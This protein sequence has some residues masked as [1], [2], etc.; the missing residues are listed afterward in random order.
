MNEEEL[1]QAQLDEAEREEFDAQDAQVTASNER[2]KKLAETTAPSAPYESPTNEKGENTSGPSS[3]EEQAKGQIPDAVKNIGEGAALAPAAV[4]DFAMD[5]VGKVPGLGWLDDEYDKKTRFSNPHLQ[6]ARE[7][8]SI[9][10]PSVTATIFA[11]R[12]GAKVAGPAL[13]KGLSAL[14]LTAAADVGVTAISDVSERD[15]T[16]LTELDKLAPNLNIPDRFKT[17]DSDSPEVRREKNMYE[18]AGLSVIGDV[19]GYAL[20]AGKPLMKWFKPLN[21]QADEYLAAQ[22][23]TL[24]DQD[25]AEAVSKLDEAIATADPKTAKGL[26]SQRDALIKEAEEIGTSGASTNPLESTVSRNADSR[27]MQYDEDG[28]RAFQADPESTNYNPNITSGIA[29]E[30]SVARQSIPPANVARNMADTT[31]L[32]AGK[33]IGDPAPVITT[34]MMKKGLQ[35]DGATRDVVMEIAE[36]SRAVGK[37]NAVVDGFRFTKQEMGQA[38]WKIY[39][40]IINAGSA[41]DLRQMFVSG[42]DVKNILDGEITYINE[43]QATAVGF[44]M[45]DL[46]NRYVGREVT[47]SSARVM[48]T[49]GREIGSI[50]KAAKDFGDVTDDQQIKSLILGKLNF[51]MDEYAINKYI[52]GWTLQNKK[53]WKNLG[54]NAD[55]TLQMMKGD[56]DKAVDVRKKANAKLIDSLDAAMDQNPQIAMALPEAFSLSNGDVDTIAKMMK[57]AEKQLN[58][59][60]MIASGKEGMNSF[61]AGLWAVR[62]NNMLSGI[63]ALRAGLGTTTS[64]MLKPINHMIGLGMESLITGDFNHIRS[65]MYAYGAYLETN[66][67]ALKYAWDSFKKEVKDP[68]SMAALQR[69]DFNPAKRQGQL[70]EVLD[71]AATQWDK[72]KDYGKL[73]LYNWD[74]T[75]HALAKH[76]A[77]RYGTNAMVGIDAFASS[78]MA[79]HAARFEAYDQVFR[80]QALG[81]ESISNA[82]IANYKKHFGPNGEITSQALRSSTGEIALNLDSPLASVIGSATNK[83]PLLKSLFTFPK[84]GIEAFRLG[85]SYTPLTLIPGV[86]RTSDILMAGDDLGKIKS[87]LANHG[88][89]LDNTPG[90]MQMYKNLKAEYAGRLAFS[91]MVVTGLTGFALAG[92]IRGNG[93]PN[94]GRRKKMRDNNQWKAKTVKIGGKWVDYSAFGEPVDSVLTLVG[95]M[96]Y[97]M[98]D[99]NS[100]IMEDILTKL[101]WTFAATFTNKT[102]V[103]QLEPLVALATG[104]EEGWTRFFANEARSFIPLSGAAGVLAEAISDSRKDIYKDMNKYVQ[105]RL[106]GVNAMLPEETDIY[107]GEPVDY[108]D[109]PLLRALSALS[110]IKVNAGTEPWRQTL[111]DIG[112]D[113][114]ARISQ[115]STGAA[116]YPAE[117]REEIY[118]MVG[119]QKPWQKI[120]RELG[121]QKYQDDM[122]EIRKARIQGVSSDEI[123]ARDFPLFDRLDAIMNEEVKLAELRLMERSPNLR[124]YIQGSQRAQLLS[125]QG[126][127]DEAVKQV[128]ENRQTEKLIKMHK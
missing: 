103:S 45:R 75:N 99:I 97:Y 21:K 96:A 71:A 110:P 32:K 61:S 74:K 85:A 52:A 15:S 121:Y 11:G 35:V 95:D 17:L 93:D 8:L 58:P 19:L 100:T 50:S 20:M 24:L 87:A 65:G 105:N 90:A 60:G 41:Q 106:P 3:P 98:R 27:A 82:E 81:K 49:L 29:S 77:M 111:I 28:I 73:F 66:K 37:F 42:R 6:T 30:A 43:M 84:T 70:R 12:A 125:S 26:E 88:I 68:G 1:L 57:F 69:T 113:G 118:Q 102:F 117:V 76:P 39:G 67:R 80:Q 14:S 59:R 54:D 124:K 51:L 2:N 23:S 101:S 115:D 62:Y 128:E 89:D 107:T 114:L 126:R 53:W 79:T 33:A 122:A 47:E 38:A 108:T 94:S 91:G 78:T 123:R 13:V 112:Y 10:I 56:F 55:E 83:V 16:L 40:D 86:T 25:T 63:S 31:A 4:A 119:S 34:P 72:D 48:D 18:A 127:V 22:K 120:E 46:V 92:N 7:A 9:I 104:D 109:N 116:K 36:Q 5:A 44:A 64:L